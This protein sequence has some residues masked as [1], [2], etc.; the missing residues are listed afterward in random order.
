MVS[1]PAPDSPDGLSGFSL[2]ES[3]R[4]FSVEALTQLRDGSF[5][6]VGI[7]RETYGPG[8]TSYNFV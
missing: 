2:P 7:S 4:T 8:E 1:K 5:D 3:L 6:G